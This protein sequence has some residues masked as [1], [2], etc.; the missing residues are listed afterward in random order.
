[1]LRRD[2]L[3]KVLGG[4]ALLRLRSAQAQEAPR[5]IFLERPATGTPHQGKVLLAV[6]AHSD[7]IPLLAAGTVAKLIQEGYAGYLVRATNDD[8]GDAPGL[9][10]PG[11]IG[12]NVRGNERDNDEVARIL[13]LKRVFNLNYGNHRMGDVSQNELQCRL[14]FLIRL[15]KVDTVV[16]W[17][18]W[19]HDEENPDH[20]T[21]ARALEAECW[22]A[23]RAHD[24]PEQFAAGLQLKT[25]RDKYYYARLTKITRG[26]DNRQQIDTKNKP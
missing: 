19:A 12:Q 17:D 22:M 21:T 8:M 7:D 10:T 5:E 3:T 9:G 1:M 16:C 13:G 6:Q 18:P 11:T 15:L 24:F 20:Y 2:F 25:V 14:I 23:G 4:A 26:V